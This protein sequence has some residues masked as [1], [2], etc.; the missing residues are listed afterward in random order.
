MLRR[1]FL[2][3]AAASAL[4]S[5]ADSPLDIQKL[6][7]NRVLPAADRYL[8]EPPITVTA[9]RSDRSAG[10]LH[11]FFSEGDYWWPDPANPEGPYIQRD[12]MS[13]PGNFVEHR[14]ALM[15]LSVQMPAL[16][17][18]WKLTGQRRY[19][20]HARAHLD[21]WFVAPSTRMNP[22][23]EYAQAIHGRTTGRGTGIIDTLHLVE[24]ARAAELLK[25][26]AGV[27]DWF[28]EYT[29]WMLTSKNG[30]EEGATKNNH[31]TCYV[32]QVAAFSSLTG[33]RKRLDWA[34]DR[35]RTVL[36]PDQMAPDGSFPL[37][38]R[39]TKPYGYSLFNLDAMATLVEVLSTS[40]EN[41]WKWEMPDGR[42][43]ARA[44]AYMEPFI[45]DRKQWKLAPDVMYNDEWPR[46]QC[47]LLFGGLALN[48]PEYLRLWARLPG[49]SDVE[50]V[51]RNFFVR[52]PVLWM[53]GPS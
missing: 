27:R 11:D 47:A 34:R 51:I 38:Q 17:A 9:S 22:N 45:R 6:E 44:I 23:L 35:Y 18:A 7:R 31:V 32:L 48:R 46:R 40:E 15:R 41:L 8:R 20:D 36:V 30:R 37:E 53:K 49:D 14:R 39:R 33:D 12:G 29:D 10:G 16:T 2:A 43:I 28:A 4:A 24:V 5:G 21:A 3:L 42:G 1:D 19:A 25:P 50:E 26:P 52:Q 13:N